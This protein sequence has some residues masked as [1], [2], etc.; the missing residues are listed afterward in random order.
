MWAFDI[1]ELNGDDLRREPL[2]WRKAALGRLLARAGS[3]VQL[4]EHLGAEGPV[5]F[6]H[7]CRM[8]LE[9]IVSKRRHS[10]KQRAR[11]ELEFLQSRSLSLAAAARSHARHPQLGHLL[12]QPQHQIFQVGVR[13]AVKIGRRRHSHESDSRPLGNRIIIPPRLLPL[14]PG[15][16]ASPCGNDIFSAVHSLVI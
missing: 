5:V 15:A 11:I 1:I 6:D 2:E 13:K 3:G 14:L 4:N 7:A 16:P 12:Q 10:D 9:G 8:G